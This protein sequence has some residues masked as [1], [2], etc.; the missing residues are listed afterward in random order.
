MSDIELKPIAELLES[1]RVEAHRHGAGWTG[2]AFSETIKQLI[3][4]N[5]KARESAIWQQAA[6]MVKNHKSEHLSFVHTTIYANEIIELLEA[7]AKG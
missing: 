4:D 7:K 2:G 3:L 1:L 6:D 5:I